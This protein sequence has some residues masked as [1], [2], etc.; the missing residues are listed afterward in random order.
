MMDGAAGSTG[1]GGTTLGAAGSTGVAGS[2]G[3]S[4]GAAGAAA[5]STGTGGAAA[6][7]TGT[8]GVGAAGATG[9]GGA[10]AV[11]T[12]SWPSMSCKMMATTLVGQM[13]RAEK[14]AQMVMA[15]FPSATTNDIKTIAPGAVFAPGGY[16]P[17]GGSGVAAWGT[18]VD[19]YIAAAATSAHQ[20]P[21]LIGADCVHGNNTASGTVIFPHN[22][23]LGGTH[24]P[25]LVQQAAQITAYEA[26]AA[27]LNWT[28]SPGTGVAWDMRWGRV[29]E[30]FSEDPALVAQMTAAATMG[31]QGAMGL[32]T[33][34]PGIVGCSKHFAG[35]GQVTMAGSW[36]S[37]SGGIVDRGNITVTEAVMR[38]V[39]IAPYNG[40][41]GAGLGSVMVSDADWNGMSLTVNS[42]MMTDILKGEMKF[43]GFIATDWNAA[44][45]PGATIPAAVMAGVDMF[46]QP[47]NATAGD[48]T[49]KTTI[50]TINT[51]TSITDA[52][53]TDAATRILQTK[54]QAGLFTKATRDTTLAANVGSMEH[55]AVA[56]KL[57]NESL[58][59]LQNTGSVLPL[60]KGSKVYVGGSG[61]NSLA[62]QMGGWTITWQGNGALTMGTTI[63]QAIAKVAT[64]S[65]T[66]ADADAI[67]IVLS[68]H[69]YAEFQGDSATLNTLP[70]ADFTLLTMA[71]ATGKKTVAIVLS[72]RPVTIDS[73]LG[74]AGAWIAAW[75]PGSEGDGVADVLFGD[76]HP[77]GKL[78]HSWP[79][80]GTTTIYQGITGYDPLFALGFGLTY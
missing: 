1:A 56:R 68:E 38:S 63:Q 70:T 27:G 20:I 60:T 32:G 28:F 45:S 41:V 52:R 7:S 26:A 78:S 29:Y 58:V 37:A 4:T 69:P 10:F 35:D 66:M 9:A 80:S 79:K 50:N 12:V 31:L 14:A 22:A 49:W 57:V 43:Q 8:A 48:N 46:M 13:T 40:A 21:L 19:P 2:T 75:L 64:V 73:N 24:D 18:L 30:S 53:I 76:Y 33:G 34:M 65:T 36:K 16:V 51:T 71:K 77:T 62:N 59:L 42:H 6:G 11:P 47:G 3:G 23:G 67:V 44:T 54:C 15:P 5:G 61:A 25:A 55:R 17:P 39:G 72:G 74:D